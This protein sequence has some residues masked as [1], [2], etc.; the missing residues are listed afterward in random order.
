MR[1]DQR[2]IFKILIIDVLESDVCAMTDCMFAYTRKVAVGRLNDG[3]HSKEQRW[4]N[5]RYGQNRVEQRTDLICDA[6]D[7]GEIAL[8][9]HT[10]HC[11][12]F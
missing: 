10:N 12:L 6:V 5:M 2:N 11:T 8:S 3:D 4:V 9:E 1:G 7:Q